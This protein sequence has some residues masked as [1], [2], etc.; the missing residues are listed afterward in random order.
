MGKF[1]VVFV[2]CALAG[3]AVWMQLSYNDAMDQC[4]ESQSFEACFNLLNP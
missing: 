2:V 3:L 1:A 4:Q